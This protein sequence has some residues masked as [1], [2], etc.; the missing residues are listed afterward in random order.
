MILK[1]KLSI[2][3]VY[4]C[5]SCKKINQYLAVDK[6]RKKGE[7]EIKRNRKGGGYIYQIIWSRINIFQNKE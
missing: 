2:Y 3:C 7:K 1:N 4:M 6:E 5:F